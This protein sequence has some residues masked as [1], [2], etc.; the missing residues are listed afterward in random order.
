MSPNTEN[1]IVTGIFITLTTVA[2]DR[3]TIIKKAREETRRENPCP[4]EILRSGGLL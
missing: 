3:R 1:W 2:P 4:A